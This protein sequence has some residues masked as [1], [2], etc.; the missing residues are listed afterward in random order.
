MCCE[1]LHDMPRIE[2][3]YHSLVFDRA[4][5]FAIELCGRHRS[6]A[7]EFNLMGSRMIE[8]LVTSARSSVMLQLIDRMGAAYVNTWI[9]Q[10]RE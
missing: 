1:H 3:L 5:F 4:E 8:A 2:H 10:V 6:Q 7:R 9:G